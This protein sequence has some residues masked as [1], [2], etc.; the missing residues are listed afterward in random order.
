MPKPVT[1]RFIDVRLRNIRLT[2]AGR[3]VLRDVDWRIRPGQRWIVAGGNGAGKT[4][5]LKLVAGAIWP[6]PVRGGSRRYLWRG[7]VWTTP[8]EVQH[9]IAYIGAERQ[10]K[11]QRYGW[12]FTVRQIIGTGLQRSD[13]PLNALSVAD[14]SRVERIIGKLAIEH[15]AARSFLSLSY[16]ERR[17]ALLARALAAR[18]GLLLLD[19]LLNGLDSANRIRA[20]TWLDHSGRSLLPWALATHRLEDVPA[21]AT[22]ALVLE[23]GRIV[24]RGVLARAPLARWLQGARPRATRPARIRMRA[25]SR[26]PIVRLTHAC[27]YLDEQAVLTDISLTV[28]AGQC[29]IVHGANGSGKTTLLRTLYG[30]HG[31]AF[32]GSIVRAG[33]KRGVP[34]DA[35]RRQVGLVAPHLQADH[36]QDLIAAD[37]VLSGR[38]ASIGLNETASR[39]QRGAARRS[40]ARFGLT[41]LAQRSLRELSYGQLRRVLFARAWINDPPLLLLDEPFAGIDTPTRRALQGIIQ[42]LIARGTAIV[43]ATHHR[44]EWP[45]G[46]THELELADGRALYSGRLRTC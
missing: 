31:V 25:P 14:D 21:T 15:L 28:R 36:P 23:R 41:R 12:S 40:L 46:T 6:T 1:G 26:R 39:A 7:E 11:Y 16:G 33:I 43:M 10:D 20:I 3:S 27:V 37:V 8:L 2:R 13:I 34:L 29:W 35:F 30:D 9:E 18:P 24:Y 17:L 32:G 45:S 5:L 44:A 38:F 4:Q 22:H 42:E 19:E